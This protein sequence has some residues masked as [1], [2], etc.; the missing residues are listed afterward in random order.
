MWPPGSMF[1][2]IRKLPPATLL[3]IENGEV[4]EWRYWRLP[5]D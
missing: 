2:G 4:K 5:G 3:S 1:K